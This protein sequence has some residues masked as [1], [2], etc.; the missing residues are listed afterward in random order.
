MRCA[1]QDI[2]FSFEKLEFKLS[3]LTYVLRK[4]EQPLSGSVTPSLKWG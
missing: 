3:L 1:E 4:F 2:N